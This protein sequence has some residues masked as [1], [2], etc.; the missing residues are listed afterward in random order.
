[1]PAR[2][3]RRRFTTPGTGIG[4]ILAGP[5]G[6]LAGLRPVAEDDF[7]RGTRRARMEFPA[8]VPIASR[9]KPAGRSAPPA[10]IFWYL[11]VGE[12]S[13]K[14]SIGAFFALLLAV[15]FAAAPVASASDEARDALPA[16]ALATSSSL[17]LREASSGEIRWQPW[18]EA[19][20]ALARKLKR[21]MLIDIGA[22]W[23]HWCHVMDQTTYSDPKVAALINRNFVP[24]K[25]DTDERPDID[26]YY[27]AAAR[28]FDAGGW[29]LTCFTTADGAPLFIAGY[30]PPQAPS[31]GANGYGMIFVLTRVKDGYAKDPKF[32]RLAHQLVAKLAS[33]AA[34]TAAAGG[35]SD[36][37][38]AGIIEA[39]KTDFD[40]QAKGKS[41]GPLFHDFPAVELM[42]AHGFFGHPEFTES[43]LARLRAIAAGGVFDQL[44][45]GV[46]RYSTDARWGVPHFEKMAY[47]QA[48]ALRAYADAYAVT[49]DEEFER[50]AKSIVGHVDAVLLDPKSHAFYSHQDADSF[51]G[52]DGSYYT[53]TAEEAKKAL[54]KREA[55]SALLYF[56][57]D[58]DPAMA[59][60]GR[61]VLRRAMS[62]A[63]VS[64]RMAVPE[65]ETRRMIDD[66]IA[67]L[68]AAR[69]K[70]RAPQVDT[71]ILVDR[72]ALMASAYLDA[73][74]AF[75]DDSMRRI[76]LD[77]L[78]YLWANARAADGS[79]YH[80]VDRGKASV[81]GLVADQVYLM[82]AMLD[83]YQASGDRK[84]LER[85]SAFGTI[86]LEKFRDS[87]GL[88]KNRVP[89]IAGT[90]LTGAS[91]GA[92]VFYDDP[93]PAV[94]ASAAQA[95]AEL[96][97]L[98]S[99]HRFAADAAELLKPAAIVGGYAGANN[100]ALG[101][102][103]EQQAH[104]DAVVAVAGDGADPRTAQL[105][106]AA[107]AAYRPG[108]VVIPP[109][110]G[111]ARAQLPEVM[112]AMVAAAA[113]R[114]VPLAFVCAGTACANPA[115][116]ADAL[117]KTIR[118]FGVSRTP[119]VANR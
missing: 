65:D 99:D 71:G 32:A 13:T 113:Q 21:P 61:V 15:F 103:L 79:F 12:M 59:P 47:D 40:A 50:D 35:S 118:D 16:N 33:E 38:R 89:Q 86:I 82:A 9:K 5:L 81:P 34:S 107:R 54:G 98:T 30:L 4:M 49:H 1:M 111:G 42:L 19:S 102:A 7:M 106:A 37:L 10:T 101:L 18:S 69:A 100:G 8:V 74:G 96:A 115:D 117:A 87:S 109:S 83:A 76:A 11:A 68:R 108:K 29:P 90:V 116:S 88:L 55:Q 77:D 70:R 75:G 97:A 52:D 56:G 46:H 110:S 57:F 27:Q 44:G 22:V 6:R 36:K 95:F 51:P 85:A 2:I 72:N 92:Q 31:G 53:W 48:M 78:D 67:K 91:P 112:K 64:K 3:A 25:V 23:C 20:F 63:E 93:T 62:I 39:V 66:A 28:D 119:R 41:H 105:L 24:V 14:K 114:K 84:H 43:A 26:L 80:V 73:A 58:D 45:G 60:N 104:G 94:Q 17:Y